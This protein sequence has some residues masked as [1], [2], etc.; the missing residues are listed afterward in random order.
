ME[1][2][3]NK[4]LFENEAFTTAEGIKKALLQRGLDELLLVVFYRKQI[5]TE[6]LLQL[7][8]AVHFR[9]RSRERGFPTL[10]L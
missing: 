3:I 5:I 9:C 1:V 2:Y 4:D 6:S 8:G 10:L 7:G